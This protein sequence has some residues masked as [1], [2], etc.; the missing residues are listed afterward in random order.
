[1]TIF[2][3]FL[4]MIPLLGNICFY[5]ILEK[6]SSEKTG[7]KSSRPVP[8]AH[9]NPFPSGLFRHAQ[10]PLRRN[11]GPVSDWRTVIGLRRF[12][13]KLAPPP[14]PINPAR[15]ASF[16]LINDRTVVATNRK[17][18][19]V[20]PTNAARPNQASLRFASPCKTA[21]FETF[22]SSSN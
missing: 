21:P 11:S 9:E 2:D 16:V 18:S 17:P 10:L 7:D 14:L 4:K 6:Q 5:I 1:M 20:Q 8:Q 19:A 12:R 15:A 22:A 3:K 13:S